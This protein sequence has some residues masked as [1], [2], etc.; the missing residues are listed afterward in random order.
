MRVRMYKQHQTMMRVTEALS[1]QMHMQLV[2]SLSELELN[3][4]LFVREGCHIHTWRFEDSLQELVLST[5]R[6]QRIKIRSSGLTAG[7]FTC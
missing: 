2:L 7:T 4:T 3:V 1:T 6:V 5:M